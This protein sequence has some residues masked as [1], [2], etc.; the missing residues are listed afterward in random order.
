MESSSTLEDVA[1]WRQVIHAFI[2]ERKQAKLDKLK[3]EDVEEKQAIE[4]AYH[5]ETWLADAARRASQIQTATHTLKPIHPDA[6]GTSLYITSYPEHPDELV[7]THSLGNSL[8]DDVVGNAAALDVFKLLKLEHNG[9]SLLKRMLA[10]DDSVK[11]ALSRNSELAEDWTQAFVGI[12]ESKSR[13]ASDTLAKQL[14]FPLA[15][16]S[17]HLLAPLFPTSLIH[18]VHQQMREDR[19][20]DEAKAS[21]DVRKQNLF[22]AQG[23]REYPNLVIQKFGGTKP[24][25]ISQLNSERYGENWLLPSLPPTWHANDLKPPTTVATVFDKWLFQRRP[26]RELTRSLREFLKKS[27]DYTNINIRQQRA[28]LVARIVDEVFLFSFE[29]LELPAG[30]SAA[31]GC[32]QDRS[33]ALW[34]DPYRRFSDDHFKKE[35][36]WKDW[37]DEIARRFGNWLNA[38]I[39]TDRTP[40]GEAEALQ[41][42]GDLEKE[43]NLFRL[44]M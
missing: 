17:Y 2:H 26:I 10:G 37:P 13:P 31:A 1:Q 4:E 11:V 24:Q 14:Y 42:Q 22:A 6:R 33:E 5:P 32:Q 12:T 21:R 3:P 38:V 36:E 9:E 34:L 35:Y 27:G 8:T 41:W 19:F 20:G 30:W 28:D 39:S 40:M 25:N 7:G 23:F 43:I 15:D 16:G 44:E 29:L 18:H